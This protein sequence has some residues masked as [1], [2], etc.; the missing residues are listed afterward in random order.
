MVKYTTGSFTVNAACILFVRL[1]YKMGRQVS[2]MGN[3]KY[4][5]TR[6]V[7]LENHK[8]RHQLGKVDGREPFKRPIGETSY[9]GV[10]WTELA[11]D[12]ILSCGGVFTWLKKL[13]DPYRG[14]SI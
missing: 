7:L 13:Q 8:G 5:S 11:Q 12:R 3:V 2:C 10:N 4:A 14:I 9:E 1:M 6:K